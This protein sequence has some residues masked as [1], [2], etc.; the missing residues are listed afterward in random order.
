MAGFVRVRTHQARRRGARFARFS[1]C[2][3]SLAALAVLATMAGCGGGDGPRLRAPV[4]T[5]IADETGDGVA[6]IGERIVLSG[7]GLG[8]EDVTVAVGGVPAP[9]VARADERIE[10][11]VPPGAPAGAVAVVASGSGGSSAPVSLAVRRLAYAT[12]F[13]DGSLSLLSVNGTKVELLGRLAVDAP[14]GPFAAEFTPDGSIAVV[15][16]SIGF[17]PG[18]IVDALAPGAPAGD[19]VVLVDAV[20][21][22]VTARI[23]TAAGSKPTGVAVAPDGGEAYVTNYATS[24]ISV[25][26]LAGARLVA[27]IPVPRQP[28]EIAV[29]ASG[30]YI[31]VA[32]DAGTASV[33]DVAGRRVLA[34]IETGGN[35]PSGVAFSP[36]GRTGWV[37]NSF[38]NPASGEDGTLTMLDLSDPASPR[39]EATIAEGIGPTPYDVRLSADGRRAVVTNLNVVFVPL[40]IGPGSLSL[41]DLSA[42]PPTIEVVPVGSAPIHAKF[43]PAG[44][45]ILAGNGLSQSVSVVDAAAG[46]VASTLPLGTTI[47]PADVAIQP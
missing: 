26:D 2:G 31:L 23:R 40:K 41:L 37:T 10:A 47:G 17:L 7:R 12:N 44:D 15:A 20:R 5:G 34:T 25:I 30:R 8:G 4:V 28:E 35:D 19:T 36:D 6:V 9:V 45:A 11:R 27:E 33:V 3:A 38:T 32:S 24:T 29:D 1:S 16:C 42:S 13:T 21:G 18:A 22:E 43:T 14:P 39:V 46:T